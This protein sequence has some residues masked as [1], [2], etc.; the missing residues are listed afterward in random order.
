MSFEDFRRWALDSSRGAALRWEEPESDEAQVL[1][2]A[3]EYGAH[4]VIPVPP[5]YQRLDRGHVHWLARAL[6]DIVANRSLQCVA[7]RAAAWASGNPKYA[8]HPGDDPL[9]TEHLIQHVA[10]KGRYEVWHAVISRSPS[11]LPRIG[12]WE[13]YAT[14]QDDLGGAL[15]K[16]IRM[17]LDNRSA[18]RGPT[19]PS[20]DMVLSPLDVPEDFI[21]VPSHCG[22]LHQ[23][24]ENM[25]CSYIALFRPE[26]PGPV[27]LSQ[28]LVFR[29]GDPPRGYI[30]GAAQALVSS[31][32]TEFGGPRLGDESH[33]FEGELD[34]GRLRRYTA[35]WRYEAI[36]CELAVSG[37][38]GA[39]RALDLH[40]YSAVQ[41]WRA[42]AN[43]ERVRN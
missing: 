41:A 16:R 43:L 38:P 25:L 29:E 23:T 3:D 22:P 12:E 9:R 28:A 21:P 39:F 5:F 40:R 34:G 10:E 18:P 36:F 8:D 1:L 42:E 30:E 19:M 24:R 2:A 17:A 37:P 20:A 7:F 32:N 11:G 14:A 27:I 26:S 35:L 33:Y 6:P 31:G 4:H 13:L 15:P